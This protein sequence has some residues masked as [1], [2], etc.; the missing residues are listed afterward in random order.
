MTSTDISHG[1]N[2]LSDTVLCVARCN[3]GGSSGNMVLLCK[4]TDAD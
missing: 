4:S 3:I 1:Q 2:E